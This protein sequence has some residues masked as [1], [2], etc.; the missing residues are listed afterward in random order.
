[1]ELLLS[2]NVA[3]KNHRS[4][5]QHTIFLSRTLGSSFSYARSM[6]STRGAERT[7]SCLHVTVVS[8]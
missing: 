2:F 8:L 5:H 6:M 1:M 7:L 3:M 4:K